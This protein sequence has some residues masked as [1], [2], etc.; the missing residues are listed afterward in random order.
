METKKELRANK[1]TKGNKETKANKKTKVNT[2]TKGN[3][4]APT[5]DE[6]RNKHQGKIYIWFASD[7]VYRRF[8]KDADDQGYMTGKT[9]PRECH[10]PRDIV[11]L[12]FDKKIYACNIISHKAFDQNP[13]V[14]RV[15][16]EK[17]M[18]GMENYVLY[19][20]GAYYFLV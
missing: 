18:A 20:P 10:W 1:E 17:Y 12:D 4:K 7:E 11:S 8:L 13:S 19:C 3:S 2:E 16:Y 14:T 6:L 15:D 5:L 9:K